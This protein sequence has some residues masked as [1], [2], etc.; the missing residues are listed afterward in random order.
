MAIQKQ[1]PDAAAVEPQA[2]NYAT[3]EFIGEEDGEEDGWHIFLAVFLIECFSRASWELRRAAELLHIVSAPLTA[4]ASRVSPCR[5][6][7]PSQSLMPMTATSSR[8]Q[9]SDAQDRAIV[10][11]SL[12]ANKVIPP[13]NSKFKPTVLA[14]ECAHPPEQCV[15]GGNGHASWVKCRLCHSR[16][17][18]VNHGLPAGT[19]DGELPAGSQQAPHRQPTLSSC[20]LFKWHQELGWVSKEA[21]NSDSELEELVNPGTGPLRVDRGSGSEPL[22]ECGWPAELKEVLKPG[23]T[24]GRLFFG[25]DSGACQFFKW[26]PEDQQ[27]ARNK[28]A[29][30]SSS[31]TRKTSKEPGTSAVEVNQPAN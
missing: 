14:G 17:A 15:R 28:R 21:G 26:D 12:A 5:R 7:R 30:S 8:T 23:K 18:A 3:A 4:P 25:C 31:G 20:G 11:N 6:R 2:A 10:K 13:S 19:P 29:A 1:A 9:I 16:W 22:C 27:R 24:Q